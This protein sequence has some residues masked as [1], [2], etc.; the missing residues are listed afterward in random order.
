MPQLTPQAQRIIDDLAQRYGVSTAAV[1]T[2]LQA[3]VNGHG[4]MAQFNHPELGGSGQWIKGGMT[5]VGD[6]FNNALKAKVDGLCLELSTLLANQPLPAKAT[7]SQSQSQQGQWHSQSESG[8]R[9]VD[10]SPADHG[11]G[12]WWPA[13]LGTPNTVGAQNS[14]RYAYFANARRLAVES[15]GHITVYDTLDHRITGVSQQQSGGAALTFTSQ[16]GPVDIAKLPVIAVDSVVQRGAA[17]PTHPPDSHQDMDVFTKLEKLA[18]LRQKGILSEE[19]FSAK[20]A[21]LLSKL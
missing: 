4:T 12:H 10:V 1:M 16:H 3:L 6:M 14:T 9:A 21:E 11:L 2:L 18:E 7:S 17:A 13:D 20:K 19:E 8:D 5:M 15:N